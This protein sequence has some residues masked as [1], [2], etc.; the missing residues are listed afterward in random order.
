MKG[1]PFEVALPPGLAVGGVALSDQL[2]SLDW[3]ARK[4]EFIAALPTRTLLEILGK[5]SLLVAP[6]RVR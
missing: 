4:A 3:H 5:A 2:K 6:E 1:Y